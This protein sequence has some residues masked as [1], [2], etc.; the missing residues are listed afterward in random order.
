[1][2]SFGWMISASL[3]VLAA[4]APAGALASSDVQKCTHG[5]E[6]RTIE[7]LKPGVVGA[8]C[9]LK[10]VRDNGKDVSVPYH[11][12]NSPDFC[13]KRA[14]NLVRTLEDAG[15]QCESPAPPPPDLRAEAADDAQRIPPPPAAEK[16]AAAD[17]LEVPAPPPAP[18]P[19]QSLAVVEPS[20]PVGA[21]P[22]ARPDDLA[23]GESEPSPATPTAN[24][25]PTALSPTNASFPAPTDARTGD[26]A[27]GR[28]TGAEPESVSA[29]A[30]APNPPANSS[31]PNPAAASK[32]AS[33]PKPAKPRAP[34]DV[35]KNVL[36]AQTAA[37]NDG[38]LDAFM[39]GYWKNPDL[40]FI[41]GTTLASGW[42]D[43]QKYFQNR[44]GDGA[45]FGK[46]SL[47]GLNVEMAS[48]D[49]AVVTGRYALDRPAGSES[50]V[51]TLVMKRFDGLWRIVHEHIS[52]GASSTE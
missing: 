5:T 39:G 8:A 22:Q 6:V 27:V 30:A 19:A 3:A 12:D 34:E 42:N 52:E 33:S 4:A 23:G 47:A 36:A 17:A 38:D 43:T 37:W 28:I 44:Y 48:N 29:E 18:A 45:G 10:Y 51:V 40:R 16:S 24:R 50:G 26:L 31:A 1:M 20:S 7:V 21:P 9:D 14:R 15:Y 46:L 25:G 49:V 11:A 2:A 13:D 41:A 32:P 35:I